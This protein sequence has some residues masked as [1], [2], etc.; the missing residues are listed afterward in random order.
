MNTELNYKIVLFDGECNLCDRSINFI[1]AKDKKDA[2]RFATIQSDAGRSLLEQYQ[3]DL[4]T[5]DSVLLIDKNRLFE[6]S[7]ALL[8]II[9]SL[10][11]A[12]PLLYI[13]IFLPK[14]FRDLF[15][16]LVAKNRYKWFGKKDSCVIPRTDI[17]YK[18]LN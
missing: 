1:I 9:R 3:L 4:N 16:D 17:E 13:L 5:S 6:K 18:F 14:C 12:Y 8:K 10:S 11:G 15:Y 7:T 2:F